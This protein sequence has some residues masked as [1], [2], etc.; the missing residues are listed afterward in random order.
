MELETTLRLDDNARRLE[1]CEV[2]TPSRSKQCRA[3]QRMH[4]VILMKS[5]RATHV[6]QCTQEDLYTNR[7]VVNMAGTLGV[8]R[9]EGL[10]EK[11]ALPSGTK[12]VPVQEDGC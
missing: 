3:D 9:H 6:R 10:P 7:S 1:Q 8:R 5:V 12:R 11:Q 4:V 2:L